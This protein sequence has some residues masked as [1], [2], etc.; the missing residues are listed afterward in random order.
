MSQ[1]TKP[2]AL[3]ESFKTSEPTPRGIADV[4]LDIS[5]NLNPSVVQDTVSVSGITVPA[6]GYNYVDYPYK[7]GYQLISVDINQTSLAIFTQIGKFGGQ[8]RIGIFNAY[9][10]DITLDDVFTLTYVKV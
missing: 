8:L 3:D 5:Q 7:S 6:Q 4:L 1:V 10:V 9:N 2:I